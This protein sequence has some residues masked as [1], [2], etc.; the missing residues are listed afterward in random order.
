[1]KCGSCGASLFAGTVQCPYCNSFVEPHLD[2]IDVYSIDESSNGPCPRCSHKLMIAAQPKSDGAEIKLCEN[3]GGSFFPVGLVELLLEKV[4]EQDVGALETELEQYL[5]VRPPPDSTQRTYIPC[6]D[7]GDLMN[8]VNYGSLSGVIV[9]SCRRHGLWLDAG[10]LQRLLHWAKSGGISRSELIKAERERERRL[11]E[12]DTEL[13]EKAE[14]NREKSN[15]SGVM[16]R[17]LG[18]LGD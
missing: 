5:A 4:K 17:L 13:D 1:M 16:D 6:P 14:E 10:E 3:C 15:F 9:D 2:K 12:K 7:C 18:L 11:A 8:R